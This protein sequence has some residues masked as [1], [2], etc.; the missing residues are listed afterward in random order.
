LQIETTHST[1]GFRVL[2]FQGFKVANKRAPS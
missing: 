2:K 1:S